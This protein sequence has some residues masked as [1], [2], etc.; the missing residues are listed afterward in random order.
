MVILN[1]GV[2]SSDYIILNTT[3]HCMSAQLIHHAHNQNVAVQRLFQLQRSYEEKKVYFRQTLHPSTFQL[4]IFPKNQ[5]E[6]Q[7]HYQSASWH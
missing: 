6:A 2:I 3:R 1:I 7:I 5:K 4:M